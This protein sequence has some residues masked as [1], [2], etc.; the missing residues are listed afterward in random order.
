MA[1]RL[2]AL[3]FDCSAMADA[4]RTLPPRAGRLNAFGLYKKMI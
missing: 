1:P 2:I 3:A 4:S